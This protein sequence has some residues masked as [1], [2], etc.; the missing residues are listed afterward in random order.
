M[1]KQ[2]KMELNRDRGGS[3]WLNPKVRECGQ[4][5]NRTADTRIFSPHAVPKL[6][7]TIGRYWYLFKRL[8]AVSAGQFY[9][10]EHIVADSSGKVVAKSANITRFEAPMVGKILRVHLNQPLNK[11]WWRQ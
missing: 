4:G 5:Q 7:V 2:K 8:T 10:F 1:A 9:R 3:N 11:F 6:C